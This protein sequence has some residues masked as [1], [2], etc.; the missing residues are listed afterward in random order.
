M[1]KRKHKKYEVSP[2]NKYPII[3]IINNTLMTN[4]C[5]P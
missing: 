3:N 1:E 4:L 2:Q 5:N